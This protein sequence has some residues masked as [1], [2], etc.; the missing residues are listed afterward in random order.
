MAKRKYSTKEVIVITFFTLW[1][2]SI[3][4]LVFWKI[5]ILIH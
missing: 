3:M 1:V 4:Y 2:L 5:K